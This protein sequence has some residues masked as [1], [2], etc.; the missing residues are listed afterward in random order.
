MLSRARA[1][2]KKRS[3]LV[4]EILEDRLVLSIVIPQD[5]LLDRTGDQ[6]VMVMGYKDGS[7]TSFGI[8]DTGSSAITFS[9]DDQAFFTAAGVQIPIKTPGGAVAQGIGGRIVG[10][11]SEPDKVWAGGL[12]DTVLSWDEQGHPYF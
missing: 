10:D 7:R 12:A 11:V 4:L 3:P 6:I 5:P 1:N 8:F 9:A 2:T